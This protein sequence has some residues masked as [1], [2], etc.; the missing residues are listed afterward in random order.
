MSFLID[1]EL[2]SDGTDCDNILY[3]YIIPCNFYK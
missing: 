3:L 2:G 1:V